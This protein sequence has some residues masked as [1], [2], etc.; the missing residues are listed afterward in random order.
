MASSNMY[1]YKKVELSYESRYKKK[2]PTIEDW[3]FC[4]NEDLDVQARDII[5][6][7]N[8][9]NGKYKWWSKIT[10]YRILD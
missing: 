4:K 9:D 6:Y 10:G 1:Y 7:L 2:Q 3:I 5:D 8:N